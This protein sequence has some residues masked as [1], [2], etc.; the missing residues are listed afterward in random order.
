MTIIEAINRVD[1]VKPNVYSQEE[2]LRWLSVLDGIIKND[3]INTHEGGESIPF[4]GYN[5]ENLSQPL[6]APHPY[7]EMYIKWIEAQID[8][9][10]GEQKKYNNGISIFNSIYESYAKHYNRTHKPIYNNFQHF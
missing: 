6:L 1:A 7:D 5:S 3:I 2:K 4:D 10:N 8:Y 9:Y